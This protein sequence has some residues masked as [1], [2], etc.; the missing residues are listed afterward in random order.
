[1]QWIAAQRLQREF[2]LPKVLASEI[3]AEQLRCLA[4]S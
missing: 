3:V 1:M 4:L 2:A